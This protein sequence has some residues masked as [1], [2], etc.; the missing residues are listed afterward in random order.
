MIS[1]HVVVFNKYYLTLKLCSWLIKVEVNFTN[2]VIII[3]NSMGQNLSWDDYYST[4]SQEIPR[5]L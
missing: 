2:L 3:T 5:I 1:K 4:G